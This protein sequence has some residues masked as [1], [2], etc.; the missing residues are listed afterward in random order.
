MPREGIRFDVKEY[1]VQVCAPPLHSYLSNP[2][3][4]PTF[5]CGCRISSSSFL[6]NRVAHCDLLLSGL[7]AMIVSWVHWQQVSTIQA[8]GLSP[9][10]AGDMTWLMCAA[11]SKNFVYEVWHDFSSVLVVGTC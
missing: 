4:H 1:I 2:E 10:L 6:W 5:C 11:V 7:G 3:D 9:N 8:Q